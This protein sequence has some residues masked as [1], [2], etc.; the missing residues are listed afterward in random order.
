MRTNYLRTL[1]DHLDIRVRDLERARSFYRPF[2]AALG[3]DV[4]KVEADFITYGTADPSDVFLAID[5]D[6]QFVPSRTRMAFRADSREDVDRIAAVAKSAGATEFEPPHPCLEYSEGYY[7]SFFSDPDGN[8]YEICHRP[9][10][11]TVARIWKGKVR[12]NQ[13]AE[14]ARYVSSTG[15]VDYAKTHGNRGA[16]ILTERG[17]NGTGILTLSFWDSVEAIE[18]FA[19]KDVDR[20]RYYPEDDRYLVEK[21]PYVEHFDVTY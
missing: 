8:R 14:Y 11:P 17:E 7:A 12:D 3:L 4:E 5:A 9:T 10:S 16:M 21:Q 20:A 18:R 6:A 13:L 1:C 15:T 19:G 2:C